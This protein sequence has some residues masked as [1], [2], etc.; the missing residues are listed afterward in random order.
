M[1]AGTGNSGG[2]GGVEGGEVV[3]LE[4]AK[5]M[6]DEA[7]NKVVGITKGDNDLNNVTLGEFN[8]YV[9]IQSALENQIEKRSRSSP[10]SLG[11]KLAD[12]IDSKISDDIVDNM[13]G[14]MF[15][16][17]GNGVN[18]KPSRSGFVGAAFDLL[19]TKFG[20]GLG[21]TLGNNA[22]KLIESLGK[23][24]IQAVIDAYNMKDMTPEQIQEMQ[25]Q[26]MLEQQQMASPEEQQKREDSI[27]MTLDSTNSS[28]VTEFMKAF[29]IKDFNEAQ[30]VLLFKQS[31]IVQR[32]SSG[33]KDVGIQNEIAVRNQGKTKDLNRQLIEQY[34]QGN[35]NASAGNGI[36][37]NRTSEG[38]FDNAP[39]GISG[40]DNV[41]DKD[42]MLSLNP[43]DPADLQK[44]MSRYNYNAPIDEIKRMMI[45]EQ[46]KYR[47]EMTHAESKKVD[48]METITGSVDK[49]PLNE[50]WKDE[51]IG[52]KSNEVTQ[53]S[54]TDVNEG[55]GS[56][57]NGDVGN[58]K[59]NG[60]ISNLINIMTSIGDK[61]DN[62]FA[63]LNERIDSFENRIVSL[64]K[65]VVVEE[66][67][68]IK[69]E[70]VND[71]ILDKDID[72]RKDV[73]DV[74]VVVDSKKDNDIVVEDDSE[75]KAEEK[76]T[77]EHKKRHFAIKNKK[78]EVK[79][80]V[81]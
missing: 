74:E 60:D 5:R 33:G 59:S 2:S 34:E 11:E 54:G 40:Q 26:K 68:E 1:Q 24:R 78:E 13:I 66:E 3:P 14:S 45:K 6:I 25:Q 76:K 61:F 73:D 42:F 80:E 18:A 21:E 51:D 12:R 55:V 23:E 64:E 70:I 57:I 7:V 9:R 31:E 38:F 81:I 29:G 69:P 8:K 41:T 44:Y 22:T 19:D 15:N 49:L 10:M 58:G 50:G 47:G 53:L 75:I 77:E 17:G 71:M 27:I 35:A 32:R 36:I 28:H 46:K 62:G 4:V 39:F 52:K 20:Y 16:M 79:D 65:K 56:G 43:D 37:G 48:I 67:S 63:F 72:V 30:R